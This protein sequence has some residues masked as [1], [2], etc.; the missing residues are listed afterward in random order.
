MPGLASLLKKFESDAERILRL[1]S[2]GKTE[3]VKAM[4]EKNK[5]LRDVRDSDERTP[6]FLAAANGHLATF[7]LLKEHGA[8]VGAKSK[9]G[10]TAF[11]VL[12][13]LRRRHTNDEWT[14]IEDLRKTLDIQ[15]VNPNVIY[16]K[17][18]L[19]WFRYLAGEKEDWSPPSSEAVRQ[20]KGGRRKN[21]ARKMRRRQTRRRR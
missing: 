8:D 15:E 19:N 3:K 18:L 7:K 21:T 14:L 10:Q 17:E 20:W 12:L 16:D 2:E 1:S 6:V 5:D 4:L 13:R 11:D 9:A